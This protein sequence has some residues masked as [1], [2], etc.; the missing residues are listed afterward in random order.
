MLRQ[1]LLRGLNATPR[2]SL[3]SPSLRPAPIASSSLLAG[4]QQQQQQRNRSQLAPRRT[5]YRKAHKGNASLPTGGSTKGTTLQLG[6]YG[7]RLLTSTRLTAKQLQSAEVA[8][9]RKL[10]PVKG[11]E[12]YLRVFPDVPVCV[13]GNE[14]RMGKG[15]GGFEYWACRVPVGRVVFEVGGGGLREEIA[16]EALRLASAKLPV[17]TEFITTSSAPRLGNL[18]VPTPTPSSTS[19]STTS[20]NPALLSASTRPTLSSPT[21]NEVRARSTWAGA[22]AGARRM[23]STFAV[24]VNRDPMTGEIVSLPDLDASSVKISPN[25]SPGKLL[26]PSKLIFGKTFTDHMLT[27]PWNSA[28]G[29]GEAVIGP[30]GPLNLDPSSVVFHYAFCLFEGMKAYKG[31]DGAV[32]LFRPDMNMKR[33]NRTAARIALP[34]FDD[35]QLIEL[36]KR[37]V[38]T[39]ERWI[40][41]EPGYSLY[42][43]PT[44]IGTQSALG[45]HPSSDALLFVICCPVGP[46]YS[47][48]FKPVSL[49]ATTKYSRAA[50]GGT[51]SYKL[52]A[53]YSPGVMPQLEAAKKGYAQN[54]WLH[55]PEHWLTEVGTMNLFVVI[56]NDKGETELITPPL[57]DLILPGVTRDSVLSIC[58]DHASGKIKVPGLPESG[59][60]VNERKINMKEIIDAQKAGKLKEIFGSGTAAVVSSVNNIGYE[61]TDIPVPVGKSGLGDITKAVL[62]RIQDIQ[63]G[64]IEHPWSVIAGYPSQ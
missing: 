9:K 30:Y 18:L 49:E 63:T 28:S 25:P 31:E 16:K 36:I 17:L 45:V 6:T 54:L 8:V 41:S 43:R 64:R 40:P 29:W 32:R 1:S 35:E 22:G 56:E 34:T 27:V 7:L 60:I 4:P 11:A 42:I 14:T 20:I 51:G 57:E 59:L 50:P 10:K 46:Y 13:K 58:R 39:D 24:G 47:T 12:C 15:K 2:P 61:G 38:M 55:G 21:L 44:L 5:K 26:P 37:L 53:N 62:D 23:K 33:M 52:G 19:T 48:G 3:F